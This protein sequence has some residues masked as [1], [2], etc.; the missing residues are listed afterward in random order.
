MRAIRALGVESAIVTAGYGIDESVAK[1][2]A[3][4]GLS[5]VAVSID[6]PADIHD[7]LRRTPHA[8]SMRSGPSRVSEALAFRFRATHS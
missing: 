1:Q 2:A 7:S 3:D 6:G 8:M 4:A 5:R